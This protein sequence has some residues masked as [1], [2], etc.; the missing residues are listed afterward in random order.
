LLRLD[1]SA[2]RQDA[3]EQDALEDEKADRDHHVRS[4]GVNKKYMILPSPVYIGY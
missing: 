1:K 4:L 3:E 2:K